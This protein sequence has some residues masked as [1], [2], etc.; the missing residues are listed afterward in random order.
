MI[1]DSEQLATLIRHYGKDADVTLTIVRK[2]QEQKLTAK[3]GEHQ[4]PERR[5]LRGGGFGGY[6][7]G[8]PSFEGN[9]E[10]FQRRVDGLP[11]R[12]EGARVQL[13]EPCSAAAFFGGCLR[14]V[15]PGGPDV[16]VEQ[17]QVRTRWNTSNARIVLKDDA[18]E[19][20]VTAENGKRTMVAKDAKGETVFNG[21][22]DT[23]EQRK[24]VPEMSRKK[25]E[26]A[27]R[28]RDDRPADA[29]HPRPNRERIGGGEPGPAPAP[30]P[31]PPRRAPQ[32]Q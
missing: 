5:P 12:S 7:G 1:A 32:V 27:L 26:S 29:P 14:D 17:D 28:M 15:A 3:I 13:A 23:E 11:P 22:I 4:A 9:M 2:G 21:P 31:L 18:G 8:L 24:A 6:P 10:N 20:E 25:L 30:E 16:K 19:I